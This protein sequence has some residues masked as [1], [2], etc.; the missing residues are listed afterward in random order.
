LGHVLEGE[1]Y[2]A[3][4]NWELAERTYRAALK[5][6]D[7][8]AL[9]VRTHTIMEAAGKPTEANGM[10]EE[11][12]RRHPNDATVMAYLG[13]R[14]IADQRYESAAK[15]YRSALERQP[16][17]PLLLNNLAWVSNELKQPKALEYAERAHELAPEN[18]SIMDTLG[19]ILVD[20]GQTERGLELLGRAAELSPNAYSIRLNFAKALLKTERK[21]AARKEL[22]ALAKLDSRLP[23]QQEAAKLLS[24]L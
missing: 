23:V 15:R 18:P 20:S 24:G 16:D 12:I 6:F 4:K 17:N 22:E 10:A 7:L 8:P 14:D 3:Q 5:K 21:G 11:W 1:V 2:V 19:S 13:E 9:V